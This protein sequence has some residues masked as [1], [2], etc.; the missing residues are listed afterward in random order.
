MGLGIFRR[1]KKEEKQEPTPEPEIEPTEVAKNGKVEDTKE[2]KTAKE[3]L[4]I[5]M[6]LDTTKGKLAEMI[7]KQYQ[8]SLEYPAEVYVGIQKALEDIAKEHTK[9]KHKIDF[10]SFSF[11]IAFCLREVVAEILEE[12]K[13]KH[14]SSPRY[15][16]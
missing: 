4:D 7:R 16:S 12:K 8:I 14:Q 2:V 1:K 9:T 6:K 3:L 10:A 11:G 15:I 5:L 13:E